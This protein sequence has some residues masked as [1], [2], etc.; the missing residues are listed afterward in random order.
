MQTFIDTA[1]QQVWQ[2]EDDV[3]AVTVAGIYSF[4]AAHGV[5][6]NVPST[7]QPYV[8][9]EKTPEQLASIANGQL[10]VTAQI[11]LEETDLVAFRCFK[12]GV[13][14]PQ[15]W[16]AYTLALRAIV[17]GTDTASTSLPSKPAYPA[18]T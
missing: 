4:T 13:A 16:Q 5:V 12:A 2:F 9:P 17:N 6:L 11:T 14:Y 1:T 3:V 7:L 10:K 15:E 18:G 8:V